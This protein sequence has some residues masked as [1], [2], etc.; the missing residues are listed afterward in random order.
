MQRTACASLFALLLAATAAAQEAVQIK[1][2]KPQ[3]GDRVKH[4]REEKSD[5]K[6]TITVGGM[7]QKKDEAKTK[8]LVYVEEVLA[9]P[10][11][12]DRAT[13]LTRTYEKPQIT[14]EGKARKLDVEGKTVLIEKKG[15]KFDFTVEGK[16]VEGESLTMLQS[17]F[18]KEGK[19]EP[20]DLML[21][22]QPVK[23][24]ETC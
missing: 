12:A 4:S 20:R 2:D 6:I 1:I 21:P 24:G 19:E 10:E 9:V 7:D 5:T 16:A 3:V 8:T 11:G 13:K 14:S 17:E 15:D 22:K 23:P 18:N